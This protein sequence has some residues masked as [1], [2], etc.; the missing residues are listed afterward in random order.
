MGTFWIHLDLFTFISGL[1]IMIMAVA[2]W[3]SFLYKSSLPSGPTRKKLRLLTVLIGLFFFGYLT[4]PFFVLMPQSWKDNIVA[5]LFFFGAVYVLVS[6]N[7]AYSI[8]LTLRN[9]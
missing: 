7:L 4:L 5:F 9:K 3:K 1:A 6:L 2:F 8:I